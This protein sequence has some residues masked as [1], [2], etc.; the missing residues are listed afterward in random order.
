MVEKTER[1][2][3][4]GEYWDIGKDRVLIIGSNG[5]LTVFQTRDGRYNDE[6]T[7]Y[8]VETWGLLPDCTGWDWQPKPPQEWFDL[9]SMAGHKLRAE[10]DEV[11]N[12]NNV[13]IPI[14]AS[15]GMTV[16]RIKETTHYTHFRCKIEHAPKAVTP[17]VES[18]DDW[19]TQ[20]RVPIRSCDQ[21]RFTHWTPDVWSNGGN[22]KPLSV[23]VATHG[24]R[25]PGHGNSTLEL[26][27]KRKDLPPIEPKPSPQMQTFHEVIRDVHD[28]SDRWGNWQLV[29]VTHPKPTDIRT[30]R[31]E[32]REVSR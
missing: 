16:G 17:P 7:E 18:P 24:V 3:Q 25:L 26:R 2:P 28:D 14:N 19:V 11:L 12:P 15:R 6:S 27:C 20:D 5:P 30:G 31:T 10:I 1:T 4:P 13:W 23:S 21:W 29:C 32:T 22:D 9:T 8:A